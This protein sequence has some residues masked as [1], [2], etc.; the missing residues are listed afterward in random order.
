MKRVHVIVSG[1]VQGV[2][3][4]YFVLSLASRYNLTGWVKNL[5]NGDVELEAEGISTRLS[6]FL[7]EIQEGNRFIRVT[8]MD[9]QEIDLLND[10][11]FRVVY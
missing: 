4:R 2:G 9:V 3:F 10:K 6:P 1:R 8:H 11:K 7:S 5:Y